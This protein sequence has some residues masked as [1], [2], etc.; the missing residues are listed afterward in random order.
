M[1]MREYRFMS[2]FAGCNEPKR[3]A[4]FEFSAC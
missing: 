1:H 2:A 3:F 4:I